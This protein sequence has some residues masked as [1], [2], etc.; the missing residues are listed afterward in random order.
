MKLEFA[1][2]ENENKRSLD[3]N[4]YGKSEEEVTALAEQ[5]EKEITELEFVYETIEEV[6]PNTF[7]IIGVL[8]YE[9]GFMK[10]KKDEVKEVYK[11]VKKNMI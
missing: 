9:H 5:L 7:N 1:K 3:I 10:E 4:L 6:K 8:S 2:Y 11:Q